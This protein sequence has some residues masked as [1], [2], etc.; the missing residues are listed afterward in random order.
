VYP[1]RAAF[2]GS[3]AEAGRATEAGRDYARAANAAL[4]DDCGVLQLPHMVYPENGR[5]IGVN[6]YDHFFPAITNDGKQWSYGSVKSTDSGVWA[7]QLPQV[8]TTEQVLRLREAGFCAIHIDTRGYTANEVPRVT[9]E[10]ERRYGA[11]VAT[12]FEDEW[13]L[14]A[15]GHPASLTAEADAL[16]HQAFIEVD[17]TTVTPRET[18]LGTTWWWTRAETANVALTPIDAGHPL[19]SLTGA[20]AAPACGPAPV[21]LTLD[22]GAERQTIEIVA[23]AK[24][25]TP[26]AFTIDS[27]RSD[28]A[29]LT[30][31]TAG[32]GCPVDGTDPAAA[33]GERR[34]AQ[35]LD[36]TPR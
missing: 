23:R 8:P 30:V 27:P 10:L 4:P 1:Y 13:Q 24:Q 26:F 19:R 20:V 2:A 6:D 31:A 35:L 17:F 9:A 22:T 21:T 36:L 28:Q 16:I 29:V 25:P 12:G 34:F 14:Y 32:E 3:V 11:P 18:N 5:S 15:I 33:G 7:A